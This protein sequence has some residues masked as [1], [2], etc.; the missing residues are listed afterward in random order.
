LVCFVPKAD[1]PL[2]LFPVPEAAYN[3]TMPARSAH[4]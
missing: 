2:G 1:I 4:I 3:V